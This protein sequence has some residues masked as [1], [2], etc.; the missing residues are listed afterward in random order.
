M[1]VFCWGSFFG[2]ILGSRMSKEVGLNLGVCPFWKQF[3]MI[4]GISSKWPR[5]SPRGGRPVTPFF[6]QELARNAS[7]SVDQIKHLKAAHFEWSR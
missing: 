7:L 6:L 1:G 4:L 2:V 5:G 3:V